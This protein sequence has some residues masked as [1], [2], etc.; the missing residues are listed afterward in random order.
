MHSFSELAYR[1]TNFSLAK[2]NEGYDLS[3]K[4]LSETG[5]TPPLKNMQA[6][7]ILQRTKTARI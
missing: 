4:A 6:R 5:A 1:C 7:W 2:I 3:V